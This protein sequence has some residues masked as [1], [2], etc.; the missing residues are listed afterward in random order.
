MHDPNPKPK[1]KPPTPNPNPHPHPHLIP[2]PSA[3]PKQRAK[4][5][6][7]A[8]VDAEGKPL[9]LTSH[10]LAPVPVSIGGPGAPLVDP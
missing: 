7:K 1:P 10:T 3:H 2:N 4:K 5:T 6:G 9:P 8:V